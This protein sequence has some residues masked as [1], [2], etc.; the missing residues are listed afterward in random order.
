MKTPSPAALLRCLE[1]LDMGV[2]ILDR[3]AEVAHWNIWMSRHSG[4]PRRVALDARLG[5]LQLGGL[6]PGHLLGAPLSLQPGP[7]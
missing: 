3:N 7:V 5:R 2:V 4:V 1:G 6:L